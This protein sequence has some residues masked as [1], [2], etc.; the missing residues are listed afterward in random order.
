VVGQTGT[1]K[2]TLLSSM[3]IEDMR[4]GKIS[5]SIKSV[6]EDYLKSNGLFD[7]V[8]TV[9][10]TLETTRA[11]QAKQ[12]R[13]A[14]ACAFLAEMERDGWT[15]KVGKAHYFVDADLD[16]KWVELYN[17]GYGPEDAFHVAKGRLNIV[18]LPKKPSAKKKA[19]MMGT[20]SAKT[21]KKAAEPESYGEDWDLLKQGFEEAYGS[22]IT[23]SRT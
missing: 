4:A 23:Q 10:K 7:E 14:A 2:S 17:Q 13:D 12:S 20:S 8:R 16:S 3:I 6:V 1:G 9:K 21:A 5:S 15:K 22:D 18:D 19:A 11:E